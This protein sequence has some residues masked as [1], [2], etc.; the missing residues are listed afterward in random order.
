MEIPKG[1][2]LFFRGEIYR[3]ALQFG[4]YLSSGVADSTTAGTRLRSEC[5]V[6]YGLWLADREIPW[7]NL[8]I[9]RGFSG[10]EGRQRRT[11]IVVNLSN[12]ERPFVSTGPETNG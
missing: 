9:R 3:G 4:R 11:S 6:C 2:I 10:T 8:I 5:F 7:S 12:H 1:S